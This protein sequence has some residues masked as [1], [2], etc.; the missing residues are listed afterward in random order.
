MLASCLHRLSRGVAV[1]EHRFEPMA[2]QAAW[3]ADWRRDQGVVC[4]QVVP[5]Q[6]PLSAEA[7]SGWCFVQQLLA[8]KALSEK[9]MERSPVRWQ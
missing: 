4:S 2:P 9:R 3:Q 7:D 1:F 8:Q 5:M 6:V